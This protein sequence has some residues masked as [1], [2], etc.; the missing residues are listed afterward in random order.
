M[1]SRLLLLVLLPIPVVPGCKAPSPEANRTVIITDLDT[2]I[3]QESEL[4]AAPGTV[5]VLHDGRLIVTDARANHLMVLSA[6]GE[7]LDTIGRAGNGPGEL[8]TP[9]STTVLGDSIWLIDGGN[10][11][12]Q[13]FGLNGEYVA[14][15]R[16]PVAAVGGAVAFKS[17][18]AFVVSRNGR[19]S[20]LA[21][22]FDAEG[23]PAALFGQPVA[24][25]S[26]TWNFTAVKTAIAQGTV[27]A[28]LRNLTLP[29]VG[30]DDSVWLILIAEGLVQRYGLGDSLK[31]SIQLEEPEFAAIREEFFQRNRA[32]PDPTQL[33]TLS[34]V[35][36]GQVVDGR[37]WLLLRAP[38][39]LGTT[40]LILGPSGIVDVRV[41]IPT[42]VGVRVFAV[43]VVRTVVYLVGSDDAVLMRAHLPPA[44]L[45]S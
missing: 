18:G 3:T 41:R 36:M 22:H 8:Q 19:D 31:W 39:G 30:E 17:D 35:A 13:I 16:L 42:A 44:I 4:L 7:V 23:E 15:R 25:M 29:L 34:F 26:G 32:E 24:P 5:T 43:D 1:H 11:R 14:S 9:R 6:A 10:G 33:Y 28:E 40:M 38:E 20:A 12:I 27:P 2:L 21:Q 37:L 45:G